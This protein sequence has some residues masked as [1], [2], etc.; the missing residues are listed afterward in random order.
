MHKYCLWWH[1]LPSGDPGP[2]G[3]PGL[4]VKGEAGPDRGTFSYIW[5]YTKNRVREFCSSKHMQGKKTFQSRSR[6][7]V[8]SKHS[9]GAGP[10][11]HPACMEG[12]AF[13]CWVERASLPPGRC[14]RTRVSQCP[15]MGAA[16][17]FG[18]KLGRAGLEAQ[19]G[20][21]APGAAP[22]QASSLWAPI[23]LFQLGLPQ[24]LSAFKRAV[25]HPGLQSLLL[26][27]MWV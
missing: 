12:S 10:S 11:T 6:N 25:R 15:P 13:P 21:R 16:T 22:G 3:T 17:G 23:L 7:P 8:G 19:N 24:T 20:C 18:G 5:E 2:S 27:G 14:G 26:L 1:L 4:G 9:E